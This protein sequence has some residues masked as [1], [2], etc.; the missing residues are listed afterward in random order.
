MGNGKP[1][2]TLTGD[3]T[4]QAVKINVDDENKAA[5]IVPLMVP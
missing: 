5:A 3:D 1:S 2:W 4:N